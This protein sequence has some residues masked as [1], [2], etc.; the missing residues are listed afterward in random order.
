MKF[1]P[2]SRSFNIV[3]SRLQ[4]AI[5]E[6]IKRLEMTRMGGMVADNIGIPQLISVVTTVLVCVQLYYC[7]KGLMWA[8]TKVATKIFKK[9]EVIPEPEIVEDTGETEDEQETDD[10]SEPEVFE[11]ESSETIGSAPSADSV[12]RDNVW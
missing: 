10:E 5:R 2:L 1:N 4:G 7:S 9:K 6:Q 8:T 3:F 11:E 12:Q